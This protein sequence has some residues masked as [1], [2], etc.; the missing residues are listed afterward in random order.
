MKVTRLDLDG[1]GSPMGLVTKILK[2]EPDLPIPVPIEELARQLD[3]ESITDLKTAG[4]EGG[5][6]TDE[7]R[8]RGIILVN[9]ESPRQ[10]RRFTIGH[11]LGHFLIPTHKPVKAEQFL[12][13][14]ENM[15]QW[16]L[17]D[18]NAYFRMEAEANTFS[19]L[20][21]MPPPAL[22]KM[23][24]TL[25]D[26]NLENVLRVAKHF[27]VSKDAAA[28]AYAEH[29][30]ELVAIAVVKDG[31]V[32]R[33]YKGLKFPRLCV[34]YQ[35]PVPL[36]SMFHRKAKNASASELEAARAEF[37]LESERFTKLPALYEQVVHQK[38][39]HALI[40][41]WAEASEEEDEAGDERTAKQRLRDRQSRWS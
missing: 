8:S 22:R 10:R 11:E 36:Q 12:C 6:L 7:C 34:P 24:G 21:L 28:R 23:M 18:Q 4:F 30:S 17:K 38:D 33:T 3:I 14:R 41:L 19:A 32:L 25:G 20:I 16:A 13:S 37:W 35:S 9:R 39:G 40:L 31:V 5:L 26:P 29:H 15:Q 1:T 27:D 2:A